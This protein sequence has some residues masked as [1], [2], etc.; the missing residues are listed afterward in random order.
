M[1][2]GIPPKA[3]KETTVKVIKII[4]GIIAGLFA[5]A[6]GIY[7]PTLLLRGVHPSILL[8]RFSGLLF[9][10]AISVTLFKSALKKKA[11]DEHGKD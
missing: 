3:D 5:L 11:V 2:I 8:G 1:I 7:L 9:V 10:A 4:F 6:H